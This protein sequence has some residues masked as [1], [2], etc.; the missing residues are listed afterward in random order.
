MNGNEISFTVGDRTYKGRVTGNRLEGTLSDG[1]TWQAT[2][3]G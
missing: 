3:R 2:K 1:G